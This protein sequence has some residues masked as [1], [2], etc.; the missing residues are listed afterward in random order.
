[1]GPYDTEGMP[2]EDSASPSQPG[3]ESTVDTEDKGEETAGPEGVTALVPKSFCAGMDLKPG[4]TFEAKVVK[5]YDD[6]VEIEYVKSDESESDAMDRSESK[7][8]ELAEPAE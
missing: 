4:Q 6:E 2:A 3:N 8:D 7:L 5:T 1:M